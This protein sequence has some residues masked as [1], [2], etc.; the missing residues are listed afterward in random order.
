MLGLISLVLAASRLTTALD[1]KCVRDTLPKYLPSI[2]VL[3][4]PSHHPTHA[5]QPTRN[6]LRSTKRSR[7]TLFEQSPLEQYAIGP[8]PSI[9]PRLALL[10]S[11]IGQP[12]L[13]IL[14]IRPVS[15]TP[16]GRIIAAIPYMP[17]ALASQVISTQAKRVVRLGIIHR[18]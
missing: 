1:C 8:S 13:S 16:C 17:M 3:T 14:L 12:P 7:V 11:Q 5:G 18:L 15:M 4:R 10:F 9:I 6:G 2:K